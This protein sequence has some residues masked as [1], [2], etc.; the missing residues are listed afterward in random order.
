MFL[1]VIGVVV[2]FGNSSSQTQ[3]SKADLSHVPLSVSVL[4]LESRTVNV[5]E[6]MPGRTAAYQ[7]A[8]IRPQVTGILK[9]RL[10][11]EGSFVEEGAALYQIDPAPYQAS[12]NSALAALEKTKANLKSLSVTS[13]RF[14][15]LV[16][17]KAVSEQ[18]YD[19]NISRVA[20][21]KADVGVAEAVVAQAKINLDFTNVYAPIS[22]II[23]KSRVT[24]GALITANQEALLA[25]IT[26]LDPMYVD[27]TL[28]SSTLSYL[29]QNFGDLQKIP[30][31]LFSDTAEKEPIHSGILK[32][33]EVT[34]DPAT[35]TVQL[36]GEFPNESATLLPGLYVRAALE[37]ELQDALLI[38]Q[39]ACQRLPNGSLTAWVLGKDDTVNSVPFVST[40]AYGDQW[41]VESGLK[42]GDVIVTDS[43]IR[44]KPDLVII[45]EYQ[46]NTGD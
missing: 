13:Q 18:E 17:S 33:Y 19:D 41:L 42:P 3:V 23:G 43:M 46:N 29:R 22:G 10:F 37:L 4:R 39:K 5:Y 7:V 36:R 28:A 31:H 12:Y 8:E 9:E 20:L 16:K 1:S 15:E 34:V 6:D 25:I 2:F 44:M 14:Q 32:F 24:K 21:A 35:S 30:V 40:R 38:P 11:I 27:M 45:P 26:Q